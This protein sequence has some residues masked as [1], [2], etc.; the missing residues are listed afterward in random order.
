MPLLGLVA[1]VAIEVG[2][3]LLESSLANMGRVASTIS[4]SLEDSLPLK[5]P[6]GATKG[7]V[8]SRTTPLDVPFFF[9]YGLG[10]FYYLRRIGRGRKDL[11]RAAFVVI[12]LFRDSG[13]LGALRAW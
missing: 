5:G 13:S 12:F 9:F 7:F 1:L 8:V 6:L 2:P 11:S 3:L 10:L 4:K